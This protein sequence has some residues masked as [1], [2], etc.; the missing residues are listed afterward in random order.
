MRINL[1]SRQWGLV[2]LGALLTFYILFQA[3]FIILGPRIWIDAP[4]DGAVVN[5]PIVTL[6]GR[7]ENAAWLTLNGAQIYTDQDGHWE[8]KLPLAEGPSIMRVHVRDR[9][10]RESEKEITIILRP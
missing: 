8:E 5:T 4:L 1:S 7:A 2:L 3:R 9:F 6:S 10:G